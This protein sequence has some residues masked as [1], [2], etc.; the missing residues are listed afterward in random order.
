M[1][2]A[3]GWEIKGLDAYPTLKA[4]KRFPTKKHML[5]KC[6]RHDE[7]VD[8]IFTG[9]GRPLCLSILSK[10][11]CDFCWA[12]NLIYKEDIHESLIPQILEEARY[13]QDLKTRYMKEKSD[14]CAGTS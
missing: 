5:A 7:T 2:V 3:D 1:E 13:W 8:I 11:V 12:H 14:F 4:R 9:T 6:P 10:D